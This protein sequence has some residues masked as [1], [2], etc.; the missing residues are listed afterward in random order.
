MNLKDLLEKIRNSPVCTVMP[1][2]AASTLPLDLPADLSE[3]FNTCGGIELFPGSSKHPYR[4]L[5]PAEF[6]KAN[7]LIFTEELAKE[8]ANQQPD[9]ITNE[10]YVV[11]ED[12]NGDY[13]VIDL[14]DS[15]KG[16]CYDA[17]HENY[18]IVGEMPV[19][20]LNFTELLQKLFEARGQVIYWL[21]PSAQ[22]YGDAYD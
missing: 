16:K 12:H 20:A 3:F 13:I 8:I 15:G 18:G 2:I 9:D 21:E 17:F 19:I 5:G 10:C 4:I 11:A 7:P 6:K 14:S 22:T 1:P